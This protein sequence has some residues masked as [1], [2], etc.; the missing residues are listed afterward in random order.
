MALKCTVMLTLLLIYNKNLNA[1]PARNNKRSND[2]VLQFS[3]GMESLLSKNM[4]KTN[5][6]G[7]K[8]KI[9]VARIPEYMLQLHKALSKEYQNTLRL[10][11]N[12]VRS[13]F[14]KGMDFMFCVCAI[15]HRAG[16]SFSC[17]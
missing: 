13:Y 1:I 4:K 17:Q 9:K 3:H 6:E 8:E 10:D 15:F 14:D 5:R 16:R 2:K 12:V 7:E 11:G